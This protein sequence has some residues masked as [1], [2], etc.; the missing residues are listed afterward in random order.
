S[1]L[2]QLPERLT[3]LLLAREE[4]NGFVD[5]ELEDL[6]DVAAVHAHIEHGRLEAAAG[7]VVA[8][9][10]HVGHEHH[11]DLE[12]PGAFTGRASS[13]GVGYR[14]ERDAGVKDVVI[15]RGRAGERDRAWS[16]PATRARDGD[17]ARAREVRAGEWT[18]GDARDGPADHELS[19]FLAAA[20]AE[21]HHVI[22]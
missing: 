1:D 16:E 3:E 6:V 4:S 11:L 2:L 20:R 5:G 15:A 19:T 14:A 13:A 7:A 21:L 8:R 10:E 17:L 12:I 22:G 18:L 9:D